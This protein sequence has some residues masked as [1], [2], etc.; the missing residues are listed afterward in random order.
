VITIPDWKNDRGG[1]FSE[2]RER[3]NLEVFTDMF[4]YHV[5]Q[6]RAKEES[7]KEKETD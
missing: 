7:Q 6:A 3:S 2:G 1:F 4:N 5:E